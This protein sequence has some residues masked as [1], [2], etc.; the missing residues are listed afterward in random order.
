MGVS[1]Q[2]PVCPPHTNFSG[3]KLIKSPKNFII[4]TN[5]G[6]DTEDT[7]YYIHPFEFD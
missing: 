6:H 1:L 3:Y 2:D 5:C 7:Y 4:Y